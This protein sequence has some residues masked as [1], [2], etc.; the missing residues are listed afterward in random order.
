MGAF[1]STYL[2]E[3][4]RITEHMRGERDYH[5][6]YMVCKSDSSIQDEVNIK[7]WMT[8]KICSQPGTV[9][10]V[11][12]WND[13]AEFKDMHA[14]Y[15]LL[16][17]SQ[18]QR[19]ELYTMISF[20]LNA[21][22]V[23]FEDNE[24]GEGCMITTPETL[25]LAAEL[26]Q[27]APEDLGQAITSKTMGGGVIEVFIK[28]LEARQANLARSST[29]QYVYC[30]V[31]DWCVDVVNDYIA[32]TS[33]DFAI[34]ILDIFGFENFVLN[35]FPQLCINFTNESLHNLFIEHVFKL[36]QETYMRGGRLAVRRVRGQPADHRSHLEAPGL[37]LR[38]AR[39]GL[40]VRPVP[41]RRCSTST[42]VFK[43]PKKHKSYIRPKKSATTSAS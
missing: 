15:I 12:P 39:R 18:Q 17:F 23:E 33:C 21:G 37:H 34:G 6:F 19:K 7:E 36:E 20:C 8:Y 2:L 4:P 35:S 32:V 1:T 42:E 9:A 31:F 16:G 24:N 40:L 43:D 27:V 5:I 3:K 28:P 22:N 10:E 29:I 11:N 26:I 25:E 14:A 38:P 30:L 13:N 41:T